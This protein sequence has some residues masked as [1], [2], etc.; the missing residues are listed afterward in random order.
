MNDYETCLNSKNFSD[1]LIFI[2]DNVNDRQEKLAEVLI[3]LTK[4]EVDSEL[5]NAVDSLWS[6]LLLLKYARAALNKD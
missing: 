3:A 6:Y 4:G 5:S 1:Q 2:I